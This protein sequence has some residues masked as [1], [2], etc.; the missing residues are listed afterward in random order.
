MFAMTSARPISLR[1]LVTHL[2]SDTSL[3][4]N[5]TSKKLLPFCLKFLD[6]PTITNREYQTIK[7]A[8]HTHLTIA[9]ILRYIS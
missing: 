9:S 5:G 3:K 4:Q 8:D 2:Y 6:A 7:L 1:R